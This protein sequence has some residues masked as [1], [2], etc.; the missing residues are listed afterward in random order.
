[1][2]QWIEL[3]SSEKLTRRLT[4][5]AHLVRQTKGRGFEPHRGLLVETFE[6]GGRVFFFLVVVVVLICFDLVVCI[7]YTR[8]D[9][10]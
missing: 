10:K 9:L 1:M 2:A 8:E 4:K 6:N 7:L 5:N 3:S